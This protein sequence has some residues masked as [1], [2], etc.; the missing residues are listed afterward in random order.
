MTELVE[1]YAATHPLAR[2]EEYEQL[3]ADPVVGTVNLLQWLGE[4]PGPAVI[5][6][7]KA[8]AATRVSQYN[9]TGDVGSGKWRELPAADL[10][11]INR[12]AGK[13]LA[14]M[15][16]VTTE[17]ASLRERFRAAIQRR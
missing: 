2:D 10:R 14:A 16:Y 11:T 1:H 12:I 9:T 3:L 8:R 13:R 17:P 7:I 6:A 15:G 5:D 4:T